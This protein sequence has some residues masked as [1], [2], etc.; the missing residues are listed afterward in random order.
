MAILGQSEVEQLM[1]MGC[2]GNKSILVE[3]ELFLDVSEH[4]I[5]V[6]VVD[7]GNDRHDE[8]LR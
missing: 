3:R 7:G 2:D 6:C 8:S 1:E 4:S 5:E